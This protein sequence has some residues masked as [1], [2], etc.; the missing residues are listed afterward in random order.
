[1]IPQRS[2]P[3]PG[4]WDGA[5]RRLVAGIATVLP[6]LFLRSLRRGLAGVYARG[7][8]AALAPGTMLAI[9]HHSWW[10][11]YLAWYL[12]RRAG[13]PLAALMD[14]AQLR[15]FPFFRHHG[16]IDASRPRELAR[17]VRAGALGVVFPEGRLNAPGPPGVLAPG[18]LR[19]ARWADVPVHPVA[20]RVA[21]RGLP[22]PEAFLSI[23]PAAFDEEELA[24][25]L[26][27]E[28]AELDATIA[29][30]D[31]EREPAGFEVWLRGASSPDRRSRGIERIWS[32]PP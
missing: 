29:S 28:L 6:W 5:R 26:A 19:V 21:A 31:P 4:R 13:A 3:T 22:R 23:G 10:D 2:D 30:A 17:R 16:A 27:A 11:A 24:R 14:D 15:R 12:A 8:L 18:V 25:R 32:E 9:N 1:M 20:L 7:E